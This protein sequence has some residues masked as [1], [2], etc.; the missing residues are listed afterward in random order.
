MDLLKF[1][2]ERTL[3]GLLILKGRGE[4]LLAATQFN[5]TTNKQFYPQAP[6]IDILKKYCTPPLFLVLG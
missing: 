4:R 6:L 3:L 1:W 5:H 2:I